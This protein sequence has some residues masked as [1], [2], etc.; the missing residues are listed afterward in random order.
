M[1]NKTKFAIFIFLTILSACTFSEKKEAG[2]KK[3]I[4]D[5]SSKGDLKNISIG[6]SQPASRTDDTTVDLKKI[7][8]S[9]FD[10]KIKDFKVVYGINGIDIGDSLRE[11]LDFDKNKHLT[12]TEKTDTIGLSIEDGLDNKSIEIIP[13][14]KNDRFN[15]SYCYQY[16]IEYE[17]GGA[18]YITDTTR[19]KRLKDSANFFFRAPLFQHISPLNEIKARIKVTDSVVKTMNGDYGESKYTAYQVK[20]KLLII[21]T[22]NIC[23][24]IERFENNSLKE[25]KSVYFYDFDPD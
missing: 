10:L 15:I 17:K 11:K 25:T 23:F 9:T 18:V 16:T 13:H 22:M 8:F 19:Y 24:K 3:K 1:I 2:H 21:S 20:D 14:E 7:I 6:I 4:I 12:I 5:S